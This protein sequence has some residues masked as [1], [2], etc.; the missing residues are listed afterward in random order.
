MFYNQWQMVTYYHL[1][2]AHVLRDLDHKNVDLRL[3]W[4]EERIRQ[5]KS[6]WQSSII[7]PFNRDRNITPE[8]KLNLHW[9]VDLFQDMPWPYK[10]VV[11]THNIS[12]YSNHLQVFEQVEHLPGITVLD[13]RTA[14][15]ERPPGTI[16][17]KNPKHTHRT[18]MLTR[19]VTLEQKNNLRK[20]LENQTHLRVGPALKQ[21]FD[22]RYLRLQ[23]YHFVDHNGDADM[24][25]LQLV[26]PGITRK[27]LQILPR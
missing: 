20:F 4:I 3:E 27:T 12:V 18:Y 26:L 25:M 14:V 15:V 7:P 22:S 6:R 8:I 11:S 16:K 19:A 2:E 1:P 24:L 17:L 9:A 13:R 10:L 23:D 21:W 5:R